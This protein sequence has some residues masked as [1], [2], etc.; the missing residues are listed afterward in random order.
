MAVRALNAASGILVVLRML[1]V[2]AWSLAVIVP[3]YDGRDRET[4][5]EAACAG[6]V[7]VTQQVNQ[8]WTIVHGQ[9]ARRELA[10]RVE[11]VARRPGWRSG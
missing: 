7:G 3:L 5:R 11:Q 1:N 8:L 9:V 10:A 6:A 2:S 4:E